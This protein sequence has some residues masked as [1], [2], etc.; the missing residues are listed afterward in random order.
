MQRAAHANMVGNCRGGKTEEC[1]T[2]TGERHQ[3]HNWAM[4]GLLRHLLENDGV[5]WHCLAWVACLCVLLALIA[6]DT[7]STT[8]T[9]EQQQG[10]AG[11]LGR[12]LQEQQLEGGGFFDAAAAAGGAEPAAPLPGQSQHKDLFP[13]NV[14]DRVGLFA[15]SIG[16]MIAAGGEHHHTCTALLFPELPVAKLRMFFRVAVLQVEVGTCFVCLT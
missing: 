6:L 3:K 15:A 16:L 2:H 8:S 4:G 5:R 11:W 14:W 10:G 13:V 9:A 12:L 7:H 1:H